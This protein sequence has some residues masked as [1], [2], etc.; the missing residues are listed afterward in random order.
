MNHYRV[1][2]RG[3]NFLLS[4][5]GQPT[6]L[7][8]YTVRFVRADTV[9]EA[10]LLAV[11][12]IRKDQGLRGVLNQRPD[13]PMIFAEEIDHVC[14]SSARKQIKGFTFFPMKTA[15]RS[16]RRPTR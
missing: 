14:A 5:D 9:E 12:L 16:R 8:F 1:L 4:L 15:R 7:G 11:D 6:R 3:E 13:P 2:L 10:E